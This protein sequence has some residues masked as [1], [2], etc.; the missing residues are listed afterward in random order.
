V[1]RKQSTASKQTKAQRRQQR[2]RELQ[3]E[4]KRA[5]RRRNL[6]IF[7]ITGIV[8]LAIIG[9]TAYGIMQKDDGSSSAGP[10][11]LEPDNSVDIKGVESA[12]ITDQT[13]TE[14]DVDYPENPPAG[15]PHNPAWQNCGFYSEP[16]ADENGVHSLEHGAVWITYSPDL[17][18]AD[19]DVLR[20]EAT[21]GG[22]VLVSPR[23]DLP[24]PIVATAWGYQLQLDS[25]D[26]PRLEQFLDEYVRGPQ[27]L[28]TAATCSGGI[29]EP[30]T[31][32]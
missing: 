14:E 2:L 18:S 19:V 12:E 4:Q 26:D 29:G 23:D 17:D 10:S 15:G 6:V 31:G 11:R 27:T 30:E 5:E 22:Y 9:G 21:P 16:I 13:H 32:E 20:S 28:E 7:G 3:K 8:A 24:S 1:A 25:A